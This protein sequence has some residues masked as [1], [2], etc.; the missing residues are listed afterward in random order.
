ME[1]DEKLFIDNKNTKITGS[2]N[3]KNYSLADKE[4]VL[5]GIP[6]EWLRTKLLFDGLAE[7]VGGVE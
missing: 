5:I 3:K 4:L 7:S 2:F 1:L 6:T